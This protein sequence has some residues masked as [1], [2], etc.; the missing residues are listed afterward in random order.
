MA[1]NLQPTWRGYLLDTVDALKLFE[2]CLQGE[3][4]HCPRR[5]HDRERQAL[6]QS[7]NIFVYTE[8]ASGIKRWTDGIHWSPSRILSNYLVYRQLDEPFPPG[9]KKR[10][11]KRERR[12]GGIAKPGSGSGS[13]LILSPGA[14]AAVGE[15]ELESFTETERQLLGSLID[16]YKFK[17]GGLIKKTI[18]VKLNN[19]THHIVSYYT[20]DDVVAGRLQRPSQFEGLAG[21]IPRRELLEQSSFRDSLS[22]FYQSGH[23]EPP[24]VPEMMAVQGFRPTYQ[25]A[26][27]PQPALRPA[28]QSVMQ[29]AMQSSMRPEEIE[30]QQRQD[31][32]VA[33]L[34]YGSVPSYMHGFYMDSGG[35]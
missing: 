20:L 2:A 31:F 12:Q 21:I 7:G 6:I 9:Q 32:L 24:Y 29:P 11:Q 13:Q 22:T 18:S 17:K 26:L 25:P 14:V 4:D 28:M 5:P 35:Y 30:L 10:A 33:D 16:S 34:S 8:A 3:L 1:C 27:Q 19:I 23:I 15:Q